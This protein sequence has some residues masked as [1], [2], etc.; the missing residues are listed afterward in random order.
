[1]S[2]KNKKNREVDLTTFEQ[3]EMLRQIN[4]ALDNGESIDIN[5][6]ND[7]YDEDIMSELN[8]AINERMGCIS[9]DGYHGPDEEVIGNKEISVVESENI[10]NDMIKILII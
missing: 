4:D 1:M 3:E 7:C 9:S 2:K 5:S 6:D 10:D 8:K